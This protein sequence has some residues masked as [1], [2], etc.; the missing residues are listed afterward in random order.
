[1][2]RYTLL[3]LL[4]LGALAT[5]LLAQDFRYPVDAG[6]VN[7]TQAPYN[8]AGDG[9]TD[10]TAAIQRAL[11]DNVG[12]WRIVYFPKGTYLVSDTLRWQMADG[13]WASML[14]LQGENREQTIIKLVD[15]APGFQEATDIKGGAIGKPVIQTAS[16]L[17]WVAHKGKPARV[18]DTPNGN[19]AFGNSIFDL[20]VDTGAGN[21]GAVGIDFVANN[22][23]MLERVTIT[24]GDG[25]GFCGLSFLRM[26]PGPCLARGV[27]IDGFDLGIAAR[28]LDYSVVLEDIELNGQRVAGIWNSTNALSIVGLKSTNRVPAIQMEWAGQQPGWGLITLLDAELSGG[29]PQRSAIEGN[30]HWY[31]RNI[32]SEGYQ[33]A[34]AAAGPGATIAEWASSRIGPD[35]ADDDPAWSR[36]PR[37]DAPQWHS[38]DFSLW[39]NVCDFGAIPGDGKDDSAAI[40]RAID[41]GKPIIYFPNHLPPGPQWGSWWAGRQRYEL[42]APIELRGAVRKVVG[43]FSELKGSKAIPTGT[44]VVRIVAGSAPE[45]I[46]EGIAIGGHDGAPLEIDTARPVV[47]RN[48]QGNLTVGPSAARLHVFD[49]ACGYIHLNHPVRAWLHQFNPESGAQTKLINRGGVVWVNGLKTEAFTTCI[50]NSDGG[51]MEV[52]GGYL[53]AHGPGG[54][55]L[56]DE[57]LPIVRNENADLSFSCTTRGNPDMA[58]PVEFLDIGGASARWYLAADTPQ[59]GDPA[60]SVFARYLSHGATSEGQSPITT[61][62]LCGG[63]IEGTVERSGSWDERRSKWAGSDQRYLAASAG[64]DATLS[65]SPALKPGHYRVYLRWIVDDTG[66]INAAQLPVEIS[67]TAGT[68]VVPIDQRRHHASWVFLGDFEASEHP[69]QV[70]VS[71]AAANGLVTLDALRFVRSDAIDPRIKLQAQAEVPKSPDPVG[72]VFRLGFDEPSLN[73]F[74][75]RLGKEFPGAQGSLRCASEELHEGAGCLRLDADFSGGGG[76]VA[77]AGHLPRK[78]LSELR[79]WVKSDGVQEI[80]LRIMDAAGQWHQR[81]VPLQPGIDW[82][83]VLVEGLARS[84]HHWGGPNDGVLHGHAAQLLLIISRK[85]LDDGHTGTVWIDEVIGCQL[86]DDQP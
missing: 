67:H 5:A 53:R 41:S 72:T 27:R 15:Q 66:S 85:H 19:M 26:L 64:S 68:T 51:R 49:I 55:E 40:Q 48:H 21:P 42:D 58:Y 36:L 54:K 69:I 32:H 9:V 77:A 70:S 39:A 12:K 31:L 43:C 73:A 46:I 34:C 83:P 7:V 44:P 29:D 17:G 16:G 22:W 57:L 45:L 52:L 82:Q 33:S 75:L 14:K 59:R 71:A 86:V 23:G 11:S 2:S 24:S 65:V 28:W 18:Q 38:N 56:R 13:N 35:A 47:I 30:G 10:D 63:T 76:Y 81:F 3:R 25:T 79:L 8:A 4:T 6:L 74:T 61:I 60:Q 37:E 1:M 62:D 80:G 78:M 20:T 50:D 84:E